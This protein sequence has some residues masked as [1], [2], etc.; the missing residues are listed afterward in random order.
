MNETMSRML[1]QALSYFGEREFDRGE[2]NPLISKALSKT[3]HPSRSPVTPW[4]SA[5]MC[6]VCSDIG[7]PHT[8]SAAAR[9]WLKW[10][11][12]VDHCGNVQGSV[13]VLWRGSPESK[14]GHVGIVVKRDSNHVWL[15]GGNQNNMVCIKRYPIDRVLSFRVASDS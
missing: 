4:C 8:H 11:K 5:F 7:I 12:G 13:A 6:L 15:I 9:S 1:F 2:P 3:H 10:G 14:S